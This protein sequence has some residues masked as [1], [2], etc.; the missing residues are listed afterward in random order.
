[1]LG[2]DKVQNVKVSTRLAN[3]PCVVVASKYGTSA[4]MERIM[5]AQAF[6]DP[7]TRSFQKAQKVLEI[8]PR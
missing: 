3:S 8:N 5:R 4:N 6:T 7:N 2:D 1:M